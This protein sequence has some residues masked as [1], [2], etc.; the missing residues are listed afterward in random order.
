MLALAVKLGVAGAVVSLMAATSA[1]GASNTGGDAA[2][3]GGDAAAH[4]VVRFAALEG[5]ATLFPVSVAMENGVFERNGVELQ[6]IS[7]QGSAILSGFASGSIDVAVQGVN[8]FAAA[9]Q[10]GEDLQIFCGGNP[11]DTS[12]FVVAE[13][14]SIPSVDEVG[15]E[16]F[17]KALKGKTVGVASI[18]ATQ[19]ENVLALL[20]AADLPENWLTMVAVGVGPVSRASLEKGAVDVLMTYP[21]I[22]QELVSSGAARVVFDWGTD[23]FDSRL[24]A[25][26]TAYAAKADW[27]EENGNL[28]RGFC[29]SLQEA[30]DF[31][32]DPANR[33]GIAD[34]LTTDYGVSA[35]AV[36]AVLA[37]DGPVAKLNTEI[38]C[39]GVE[40]AMAQAQESGMIAAHPAVT[41]DDFLW[42]GAR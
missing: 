26:Y 24:G 4:G 25:Y 32:R 5:S 7:I 6:P 2:N 22:E 37:P 13:D 3:T 16:G 40:V 36:D 30:L 8:A 39:P 34:I 27:L 11:R 17:L 9:K 12:T 19:Y 18:G 33:G 10:K 21:F 23:N 35:K 38:D 28:A 29:D 15:I 14:S 20:S 41:C 31:A 42:E 1:C